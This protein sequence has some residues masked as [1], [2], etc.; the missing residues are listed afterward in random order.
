MKKLEKAVLLSSLICG[1]LSG[2]LP[3]G[4]KKSVKASPDL[5]TM[6]LTIGG[7]QC[8]DAD[9][10]DVGSSTPHTGLWWKLMTNTSFW[11]ILP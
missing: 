8:L 9:A 5:I 2:I 11:R 6:S 4:F 10:G 1:L 7:T 3:V